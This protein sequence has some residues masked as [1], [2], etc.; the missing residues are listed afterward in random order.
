MPRQCKASSQ[1]DKKCQA[2]P[3]RDGEFCLFHDPRH[4]EA[5]QKSRQVGGQRRRKEAEVAT[6]YDFNG[7]N[8]IEDIR[9]LVEV[10]VID[11][12]ILENSLPRAR[13]LAH[14][15]QI[16]LRL[17]EKGEFE[18]RL[19]ALEASLGPRLVSEKQR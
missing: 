13:T 1:N 2:A 6:A 12:L 11:T 14:L 15:A 3:L 7:L 16:A 17:L 19:E 18:E 5:V 8:S 9:R 4:A 10:A